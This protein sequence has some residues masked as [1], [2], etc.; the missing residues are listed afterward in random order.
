MINNFDLFY[1]FLNFNSS[2]DFY[3]LQIIR[4]GKDSNLTSADNHYITNYFIK[5]K[6]HLEKLR[7][8]I[9][10]ICD[11]LNARAYMH[12]NKRSFRKTAYRTLKLMSDSLLS[13]NYESIK[14]AYTSSC[15]SHHNEL[16][17]KWIIDIDD[18]DFSLPDRQSLLDLIGKLRP[19]G[20]KFIFSYPTPNGEHLVVK[21][22]DLSGL[23]IF[24]LKKYD[25]TVFKDGMSLLYCPTFNQ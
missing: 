25:I 19:E 6:E 7:E 20:D 10:T 16:E 5:S 18:F 12:L 13:G 21:P 11:N 23:N 9:I 1:P 4:R 17:K 24:F 2:D 22:F 3:F 8:E 14:R 15:G